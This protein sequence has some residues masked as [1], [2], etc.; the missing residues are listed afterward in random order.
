MTISTYSELQS[1]VADFLNRQDLTAAI[2]TFIRLAEARIDRD[3]LHWRQEVRSEGVLMDQYNA[4][5]ADFIRPIRLQLLGSGTNEVSLVS[6]ATMLQMRSDRADASG[7]PVHYAITSGGLELFPTPDGEYASSLVYY[8][9]ITPL[10]DAAPSNWLLAEAPDVYLYGA[11]VHSAPYLKD[12]ARV[13][14]WESFFAQSVG[15]MNAASEG[16]KH[17]GSGL[18]MRTRR[19]AA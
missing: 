16:A 15:A 5:P 7:R 11:L 8:G 12:D 17:G 2:P 9:R 13:A 10:S 19:G 18:V 1:A 6:T 4:I 14:L 3:M